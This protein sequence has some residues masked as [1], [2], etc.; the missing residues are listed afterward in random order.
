MHINK[1]E[2]S[3]NYIAL[4]YITIRNRHTTTNQPRSASAIVVQNL[5]NVDMICASVITRKQKRE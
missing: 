3:S 5:S 1:C 4:D 2:E